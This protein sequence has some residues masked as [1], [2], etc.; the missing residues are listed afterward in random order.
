MA[1]PPNPA[2][3]KKTR[4]HHRSP[5]PLV[6]TSIVENCISSGNNE[7]GVVAFIG[8]S[9]LRGNTFREN[10]LTGILVHAESDGNRIEGNHVAGNSVGILVPFGATENVVFGNS[11]VANTTNYDFAVGNDDAPVATVKTAVGP[12][13]NIALP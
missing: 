3:T 9:V 13:V 12:W 10:T 2:P 5:F 11:A 8:Q 1:S 6:E 4:R 7:N